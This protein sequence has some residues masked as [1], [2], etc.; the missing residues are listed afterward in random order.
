MILA[1][2][3]MWP[4]RYCCPLSALTPIGYAGLNR[5]HEPQAKINH[6]HIIAVHDVG[7]HD[8]SPYMICELLEGETLR[9]RLR[10]GPFAPRKVAEMGLQIARGLAAAHAKGVVHRDLKPDNLFLTTDE[11]IKIL[12]FGIAQL[13]ADNGSDDMTIGASGHDTRAGIVVG[14]VGYMSPEQVRGESVDHRSDLFA[15]GAILYELVTGRRAF[16]AETVSETM[17]AILREDPPPVSEIV[18][19]V[20]PAFEAILAHCLV[21]DRS[22]RVQSAHDLAFDLELVSTLSDRSAPARDAAAPAAGSQE[23]SARGPGADGRCRCRLAVRPDVRASSTTIIG[24]W[25]P[26]SH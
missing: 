1:S 24:R 18:P 12:D 8:G 20:P 9:T 23:A 3:E 15:V 26:S 17:T 6:P 14:T 21:K 2:G 22:S 7:L 13:K 16:Q 11:R 5:K 4:S 19:I 10:S 25:R